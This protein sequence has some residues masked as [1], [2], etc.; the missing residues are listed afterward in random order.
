MK[1]VIKTASLLCFIMLILSA[2][3]VAEYGDAPD[4]TAT[5]YPGLFE[6]TGEFPTL[7]ANDGARTRTINDAILGRTASREDDA[8]DPNDPDGQSNLNPNNTDS[9]DGIISMVIFLESIPCPAELQVL[10][11]CP[12]TGNGGEYFL[13]VLI[14]LNMNGRW[15]GTAVNNEPEWVVQNFRVNV[16]PGDSLVV[17]PPRFFFSS[18]NRLPENAWMRIALTRERINNPD[19]DGTG[20]FSSGEIEDHVI[21][22]PD[23]GDKCVPIPFVQLVGGGNVVQF[24]P[25]VAQVNFSLRVTD[26]KNCPNAQFGWDISHINGGMVNLIQNPPFGAPL[27]PPGGF[28]GIHPIN[29]GGPVLLNFTAIRGPVLPARYRVRAW[30]IDPVSEVKPTGVVIGYTDCE[31]YIEFTG[32]EQE[33]EPDTEK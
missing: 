11:T 14:D 33:K 18:G 16:S 6:Q 17:I 25:G 24:P 4:G 20:E 10:V 30:G 12:E 5:G 15:G 13:N 1:N 3:I 19:W 28:G 2:C 32:E 9:D 31:N 29:M 22:L 21:E 27:P 23:F 26:L 8:N 7:N